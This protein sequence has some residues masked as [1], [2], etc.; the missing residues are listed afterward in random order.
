ME[1]FRALTPFS[2]GLL[3]LENSA[4]FAEYQKKKNMELIIDTYI[5]A[6]IQMKG[7][8]YIEETYCYYR[9]SGIEFIKIGNEYYFG[10]SRTIQTLNLKGKYLIKISI[11]L[12]VPRGLISPKDFT[13]KRKTMIYAMF[14][15][16]KSVL[17]R[18]HD[19]REI[20]ADGTICSPKK[21]YA[22]KSECPE[23]MKS[24]DIAKITC[25]L[26]GEFKDV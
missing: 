7:I 25:E 6:L 15:D 14:N 3:S 16:K 5:S 17:T 19:S 4:S 18:F 8:K 12:K 9:S 26:L 20:V 2:T 21:C 13:G 22:Y 24:N 1:S 23:P 11:Y 10:I